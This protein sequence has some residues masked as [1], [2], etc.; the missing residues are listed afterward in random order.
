[1]MKTFLE[2]SETEHSA[3]PNTHK[4]YMVASKPLLRYFRTETLLAEIT[5]DKVEGYKVW[6]CKQAKQLPAGRKRKSTKRVEA[7]AP[8][9]KSSQPVKT[10]KPATINRELA[11]LKLLFNRNEEVAPLNPVRKVKFL[12]ED[13]EQMRVLSLEEERLYLLAASQPLHDIA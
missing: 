5:R 4:R 6:R 7:R 12:R 1:A 9:R 13:N 10:L 8:R 11:C 2:W 3:H